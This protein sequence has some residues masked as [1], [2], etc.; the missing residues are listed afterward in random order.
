[1]TPP[2]KMLKKYVRDYQELMEKSI[3]LKSS[4]AKHERGTIWN[5]SY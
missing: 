3:G 2:I 1:M 4:A 5:P